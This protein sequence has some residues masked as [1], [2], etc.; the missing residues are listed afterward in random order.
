MDGK[1]TRP[2]E[3]LITDS[4]YCPATGKA[5]SGIVNT[6]SL[7]VLAWS[8]GFNSKAWGTF[9]QWKEMGENVSVRKGAKAAYIFVPMIFTKKD[10]TGA[11]ITDKDGDEVKGLSFKQVAVFNAEEVDGFVET[12]PETPPCKVVDDA[13]VDKF[14]ANLGMDLSFGGDR[15]YYSPVGDHTRMPPKEAF[16]DTKFS[17]ATEAYYGTLL[18]ETIHWTGHETRCKRLSLTTFGTEAY[19]EEE[20]VAEMGATILCHMFGVAESPRADHAQYIKSWLKR[21]KNDKRMIFK[22]CGQAQKA[23]KWLEDKQPAKV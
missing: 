19:A 10:G 15:A 12:K 14:I 2:W 8:R 23:I 22:A 16:T 13:T 7:S 20:L 5:Y 11:P 3:K 18:H 6:M 1:W 21:L 17:T 4:H 9:K